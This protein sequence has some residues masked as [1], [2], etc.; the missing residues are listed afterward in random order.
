MTLILYGYFHL[1]LEIY[2]IY[3]YLQLLKDLKVNMIAH[4]PSYIN[5]FSGFMFQPDSGFKPMEG[6]F[7]RGPGP[8]PHGGDGKSHREKKKRN[9]RD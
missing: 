3:M 9:W 6:T 1:Y 4:N 8:Q 7:L 5:N 2:Y